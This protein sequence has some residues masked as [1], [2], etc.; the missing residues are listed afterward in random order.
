MIW[1]DPQVGWRGDPRDRT[2][3]QGPQVIAPSTHMYLLLKT[4]HGLPMVTLRI[5][6]KALPKVYRALCG[7]PGLSCGHNPILPPPPCAYAP[8]SP[9]WNPPSPFHHRLSW[10]AFPHLLHWHHPTRL[11]PVHPSW[12]L[13]H[14]HFRKWPPLQAHTL[15]SET[16]AGA[17]N[18][19]LC[20]P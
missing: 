4:P 13:R 11:T 2:P 1:K 15:T 17:S 10:E 5:K 9:A 18:S 6:M 14:H 8:G 20:K 3:P 7:Q 19:H 16:L 12:K